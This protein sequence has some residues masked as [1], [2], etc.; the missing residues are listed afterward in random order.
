MGSK[1]YH[2]EATLRDLYINQGLTLEQVGSRFDVSTT[3]IWYWMERYDIETS[4][5]DPVRPRFEERYEVNDDT[6]CWEWTAGT[7]D[8][9]YG[10]LSVEGDA[11]GAHRVSYRLHNGEIPDG[12]IICHTCDNPPCV[13]P[14]HLYAGDAE[15]NAQDAKDAGNIPRPHGTEGPKA[16]LT[17]EEVVTF[18]EKYANGATMADLSEEYDV[19][20]ATV[21][22]I[23]S[24]DAYPNI[25]GPTDRRD[26]FADGI[27]AVDA[28][29]I[30]EYQS[31]FPVESYPF[32]RVAREIAA[33]I[34]F[35]VDII[36]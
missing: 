35:T 16:K 26:I 22:R 15:S 17:E 3:T 27:D 25:G 11:E 23:T 29:L 19:S 6:G 20:M 12:A 10:A 7:T 2:D 28:A 36:H 1:P 9:G 4:R 13:N 5:T 8:Y 24:G 33:A 34:I 30:D 18:R 14:D 31:G 32:E 21:S